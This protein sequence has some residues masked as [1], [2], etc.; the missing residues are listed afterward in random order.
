MNRHHFHLQYFMIMAKRGN[1]VLLHKLAVWYDGPHKIEVSIVSGMRLYTRLVGQHPAHSMIFFRISWGLWPKHI[2]CLWCLTDTS[3]DQSK[4]S[5]VFE[6][7]KV[8]TALIIILPFGS[9][10]QHVT[11]SWRTQTIIARSSVFCENN[12][13]RNLELLGEENCL[14]HHEEADCIIIT[15]IKLLLNQQKK[16]KQLKLYLIMLIHLHC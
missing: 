9:I 4:H 2:C 13:V 15:H 1:K 6:Q 10:S 12:D 3:K 11:V 14:F 16:T 7:Q 8:H 5:S